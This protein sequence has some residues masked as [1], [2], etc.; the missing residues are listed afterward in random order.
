MH[1]SM[2]VI[3]ATVNKMYFTRSFLMAIID[4]QVYFARLNISLMCSTKLITAYNVK[5]PILLIC[6]LG[7][8]VGLS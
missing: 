7:D 3:F 4:L 6:N 2:C 5:M 8:V 1:M